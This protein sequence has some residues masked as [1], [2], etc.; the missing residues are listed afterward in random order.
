MSRT[1]CKIKL[2]ASSCARVRATV[3]MIHEKHEVVFGP[4]YTD[5]GL[6]EKVL[7]LE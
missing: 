1:G 6:S 7:A 5:I 3:S 4:I 2:E